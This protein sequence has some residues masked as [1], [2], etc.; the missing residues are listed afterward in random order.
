[1]VVTSEGNLASA[2]IEWALCTHPRDVAENN[3]VAAECL[4]SSG[5]D[6]AP[7]GVLP[8]TEPV[9]TFIPANACALFGSEPAPASPG[10]TAARPADPDTTG[11]YYAPIRANIVE[12][13]DSTSELTPDLQAV[14]HVRVR[15]ALPAAPVD[16][17]RDYVARYTNNQNPVLENLRLLDSEGA[18]RSTYAGGEV[19]EL[20]ASWQP[21]SAEEFVVYDSQAKELLVRKETLKVSW[22]VTR[23]SVAK[24]QTT[25][26]DGA[27]KAHVAFTA[28]TDAEVVQ[29]WAV[30]RD[31]RGGMSWKQLSVTPQ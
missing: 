17:A 16:I 10:E 22:F 2:Q 26:E 18:E 29:I 15:C 19:L 23:G 3:S 20:A 27:T 1:L 30:V 13:M 14:G 24:D 21:E 8:S 4:A 11:G 31:S 6:L 25:A 7:V 12:S 28:P 9:Q 5:D